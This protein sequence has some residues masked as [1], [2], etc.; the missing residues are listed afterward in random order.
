M[1]LELNRDGMQRLAELNQRIHEVAQTHKRRPQPEVLAA[2]EREY[3]AADYGP[4]D[5]LDLVYMA[6]WIADGNE[7]GD[8]TIRSSGQH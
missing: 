2:L 7:L 8:L 1:R 6:Q 5:G 3:A 4:T